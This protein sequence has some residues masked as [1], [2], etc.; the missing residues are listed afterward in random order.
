MVESQ[1]IIE[2]VHEVAGHV[3]DSLG[4]N[5]ILAFKKDQKILKDLVLGRLVAPYSKHRLHKILDRQFGIHHDLDTIY[6]TLDKLFEKM[7]KV[8]TITF[9]KTQSLFPGP[10]D[11]VFF[12]V[13]TLYFEST[14]TDNLREFGYSKD[15]RFNTTQVVLALAT[16]QDG[17]P[18]GY[19]LFA[20]NTAEVTTLIQALDRWQ[21]SFQFQSICFV[22]D[23]AMFS[24]AN[25]NLLE[26]R[27]Y[28]YVIAAKLKTLPK[29]MQ[30][31]LWRSES[32]RP[33]AGKDEL[34]WAADFE[35]QGRRLVVSYKQQRAERDQ[36]KRQEV[37]AKIEKTLGKSK[38]SKKAITN[39]GIKKYTTTDK[40]SKTVI[41]TAKVEADSLWDG[42]HGVMT[43]MQEA[44]VAELL[45]RYARLWVIE[46][47]FRINKHTLTMRPIYHFKPERIQAHIAMC[48]MTFATLRHLQY[49]ANLTT[50]VSV[51]YIVDELM[52]VQTSIYVHK[53]TG[54]K[55]RVPGVF[56]QAAGKIYKCFG[57]TRSLDATAL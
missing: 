51:E 54:D 42:L 49:R 7:A 30:E 15:H 31:Q 33:L 3:Y 1:R 43:N 28:T 47:S 27:G 38:H 11:L 17:L 53:K 37:L 56:S 13:T 35:Y 10:L 52:A 50:K 9:L 46:E 24:E 48:Y 34:V 36:T 39:R 55:Y 18:I 5:D 29:A 14:T 21:Q 6:R 8:K 44:T 19:E 4:Y 57:L 40:T 45:A 26:E 32:Y 12:D 41:D 16:S 22:G 2:G 25:L 23:R 20:G